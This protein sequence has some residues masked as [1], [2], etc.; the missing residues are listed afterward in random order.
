MTTSSVGNFAGLPGLPGGVGGGPLW[1]H[2]PFPPGERPCPR[3]PPL[4][5]K[6]SH[7]GSLPCGPLRTRPSPR[8]ARRSP[9]ARPLWPMCL[10][11]SFHSLLQVPRR[12]GPSVGSESGAGHPHPRPHRQLLPRPGSRVWPPGG[13]LVLGM[14]PV[15]QEQRPD[16]RPCEGGEGEASCGLEPGPRTYDTAG[17]CCWHA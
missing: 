7:T 11:R 10:T 1:D 2:P 5:P 12:P 15:Q 9:F 4:D 8:P 13:A 6:P 16:R 3:S 14:F 17:A